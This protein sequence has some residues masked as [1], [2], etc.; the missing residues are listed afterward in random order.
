MQEHLGCEVVR[1][2][3]EA[4]RR[5][6]VSIHEGVD[7]VPIPWPTMLFELEMC[8]RAQEHGAECV[9]TGGGGDELFDG[10]PRSLSRL[11]A[12][13]HWITAARSARRLNGFVRPRFP[14]LSLVLR[15]LAVELVPRPIRMRRMT[16]S[17]S[18][19]PPWAG[20]VARDAALGYAR[21]RAAEAFH[22]RRNAEARYEAMLTRQLH[23]HV[24]WLRHQ[25][26][27]VSGIER[28]DPYLDFE[29]VRTVTAFEP[30]WLIHGDER[31]GLF[32]EA[33]RGLV[34]EPVR[35]RQDKARFEPA[36]TR[37]FAGAQI[38]RE[39]QALTSGERLAELGVVEPRAFAT[40]ARGFL[41]DPS[42]EAWISIW[43]SLACEAFL[44]GRS[45]SSKAA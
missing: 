16:R 11:A 41:E 20:H 45:A 23:A 31:R 5:N 15:P 14:M 34:P 28:R 38:H 22:A 1:F 12:S 8:R 9:L 40:S 30:A 33:V 44:R 26:W 6:F 43:P 13:G 27:V 18:G 24:P 36:F 19:V 25:D 21:S 17:L 4:A 32:R 35:T 42:P 39:L 37:L 2:E 29:F 3:P 7:A 10:E